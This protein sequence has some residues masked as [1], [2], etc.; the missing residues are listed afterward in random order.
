MAKLPEARPSLTTRGEP[1]QGTGETASEDVQLYGEMAVGMVYD[2]GRAQRPY[3]KAGLFPELPTSGA[4]GG[5]P[6]LDPP[7]GEFI[8]PP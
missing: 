6:G 5:L 8:Q 2:S 7:A 3:P 1:R 4:N